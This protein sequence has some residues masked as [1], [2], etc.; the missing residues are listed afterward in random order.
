MDAARILTQNTIYSTTYDIYIYMQNLQQ[1]HLRRLGLLRLTL[2]I[3]QFGS[4]SDCTIWL[5]YKCLPCCMRQSPMLYIYWAPKCCQIVCTT[6]CLAEALY[7]WNIT[8]LSKLTL[9]HSIKI[10]SLPYP[11]IYHL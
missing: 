8:L 2:I 6:A 5:L 1:G 11:F 9:H 7:V 4:V 10:V 3:S